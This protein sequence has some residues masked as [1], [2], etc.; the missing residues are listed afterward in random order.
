MPLTDTK[1]KQAKA[2]A[3]SYRLSDER[4]MYLEVSTSGSKYW[5]LKY[6]YSGKEKRLALGVYPEVSLK[7]ARDLRDAARSLLKDGI[8]PSAHKRATK[9]AKSN[10]AANS[11]QIV[12]SEWYAK[13][14]PHWSESH[15][16]R[17]L[18]ILEKDLF[19]YLGKRPIIEITAPELLAVL[20][21]IESRGALE[22]THKAK[23]LA[24]QV[25]RYGIAT[26]RAERDPSGDLKGALAKQVT[27]HL[28]SIT[29]P[30]QVGKLLVAMDTYHGT[31]TVKTALALSPL[32]LCRPGELRHME[33]TEINWDDKQWE[34]SAEKMKMKQPHIIPLSK[35]ALALLQNLQLLTG[36][37][38]YVFPNPRGASRPLSENG[39]RVAIR[40]M[41]YDNEAMTPHGFRAMGRKIL[42]EVLGYRI[43]WIEC[44]LA[45]AVKDANGRAYNRTTYLKQRRG[46][47]QKWADYLDGLRAEAANGN[48]ISGN[49]KKKSH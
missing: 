43:E 7:K 48:V 11:F 28:A 30:K 27:K 24:G 38:K 37:G 45:H 32:L 10:Q 12:A 29:D 5:R 1:A 42:D 34:L 31:P 17:V 21:R 18:R 2:E 49:F 40:T 46:M 44:Q 8:D 6:R 33:W 15:T 22:T 39:V 13:E 41:G 36:Q 23:Q 9:E 20:R 26:G 3:K 14:K 16:K 47:L 4:G 19:P 25:F 35:Q